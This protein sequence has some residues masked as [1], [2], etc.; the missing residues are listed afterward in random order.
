[1]P[2]IYVKKPFVLSRP[3]GGRVARERSFAVGYHDIDDETA[4]HPYIKDGADGS[5]ETPDEAAI[6]EI[7][8]KA[9]ATCKAAQA[10]AD[11]QVADALEQQ[12]KKRVAAEQAKA[13]AKAA[14]QQ[15]ADAKAADQAKADKAAADKAAADAAATAAKKP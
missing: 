3:E 13:Q 5:I 7:R 10:E 8:E 2:R 9:D 1:M 12:E 4:S 14:E 11:K 6:R 15:K